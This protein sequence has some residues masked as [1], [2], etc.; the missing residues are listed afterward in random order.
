VYKIKQH[1]DGWIDQYKAW[2]VTR[3]FTQ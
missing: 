2:L 1:V 3:G